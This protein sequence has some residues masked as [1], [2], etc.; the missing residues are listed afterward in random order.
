VTRILV[1]DDE[2]QILRALGINLRARGYDVELVANGEGALRLAARIH[3][4][5]VILD[6][7]LPGIDG[8]EVIHGLRGWTRVPIIVLSVREN[9]V[10]KVEALDAG[11][12]D[13]VTK[14]FGMDELVARLRAALRRAE[15]EEEARVI[16]TADFSVDLGARAIM[17]NGIEVRLTP[18]EWQIVE[19]LVR[20]PNKLIT[21][22]QL[23]KDVWGPTYE[24]E[25]NYLRVFMAQIRHKLEPE[26]SR[27]R[28][29]ITEP[30]VGYRFVPDARQ[31]TTL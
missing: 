30:R 22:R 10:D 9:E 12:D 27:P 17:R 21:Q 15:P 13:Y 28:Y 20:H 18:T 8:V 26:P 24:R 7:G 4:D 6:L 1:V 31:P 25:T 23:L 19:V 29:F 2:P 16:A 11:A 14:P 3:P 5:L